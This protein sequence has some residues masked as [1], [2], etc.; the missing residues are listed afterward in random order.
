MVFPKKD[1]FCLLLKS[2]FHMSYEWG[3]RKSQATGL[4]YYIK[5]SLYMECKKE[6]R[7]RIEMFCFI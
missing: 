3:M 1:K 4:L 7:E 5:S 2:N 6:E